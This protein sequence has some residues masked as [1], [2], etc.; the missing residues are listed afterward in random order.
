[1]NRVIQVNEYID[2]VPDGAKYLYSKET[3]IEIP[4]DD[5]SYINKIVNGIEGGNNVIITIHYFLVSD[6]D[7]KIM[8]EK[9]H[10]LQPQEKVKIF[11]DKFKIN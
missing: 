2:L 3:K 11:K 4:E 9:G 5:E 7:F 10:L 6:E 8:V 1:M